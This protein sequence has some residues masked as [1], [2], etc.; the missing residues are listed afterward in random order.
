MFEEFI[1]FS[2]RPVVHTF[3]CEKNCGTFFF[4]C[5]LYFATDFSSPFFFFK[6]ENQRKQATESKRVSSFFSLRGSGKEK[7]KQGQQESVKCQLS[8]CFSIIGNKIL[9]LNIVQKLRV[10]FVYI[11]LERVYH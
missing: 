11:S 1:R 2:H 5:T 3:F 10:F 7:R 9:N 8:P 6:R 4:F